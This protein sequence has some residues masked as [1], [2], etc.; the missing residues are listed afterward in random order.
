M[1]RHKIKYPCAVQGRQVSEGEGKMSARRWDVGGSRY[2][3]LP[4]L[5]L[6]FLPP[7][8]RSATQARVNTS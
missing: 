1:K 2:F 7:M 4:A 5:I 8:L 6:T 3:L